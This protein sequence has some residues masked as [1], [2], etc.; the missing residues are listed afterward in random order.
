[1]I[2]LSS[3]VWLVFLPATAI[4]QGPAEFDKTL[5]K[6]VARAS[7]EQRQLML[8]F[9]STNCKK[10][11][12]LDE[13]FAQEGVQKALDD[14]YVS[15]RVNIDE[16]DGQACGQIYEI[17]EVPAIVVVKPDGTITAKKQGGVKPDDI[18][19]L[20]INGFIPKSEI[21]SEP[22]AATDNKKS[23]RQL[24]KD[25][26]YALQVGFFSNQENANNLKQEIES[27]GYDATRVN[28]EQRDNK[29]FYRVLVGEYADAQYARTDMKSL[30][31]SGFSVKVHKYRP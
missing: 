21:I 10:C 8:Y 20:V 18:H 11:K 5:S 22:M 30:E 31:K 3:L 4:F 28:P 29:T 16:F 15:A 24:N 14:R 17:T 26:A 25:E 12:S 7:D 2:N 13:Y 1:M 27:K 9:T 23:E 19:S 6:A